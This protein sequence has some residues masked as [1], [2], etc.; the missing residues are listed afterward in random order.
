MNPTLLGPHAHPEVYRSMAPPL[1]T[2]C[3]VWTQNDLQGVAKLML[4]SARRLSAAPTP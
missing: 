4:D 1:L 3:D 2:T